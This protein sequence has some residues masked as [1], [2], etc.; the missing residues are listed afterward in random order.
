MDSFKVAGTGSMT[1]S[2]ILLIGL[3]LLGLFVATRLHESELLAA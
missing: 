1:P 3:L 2:L